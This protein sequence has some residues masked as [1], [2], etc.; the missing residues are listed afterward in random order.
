MSKNTTVL[1]VKAKAENA[2]LIKMP[3]FLHEAAY[4]CKD[5]YKYIDSSDEGVLVKIPDKK[6]KKI[7]E[8]AAKMAERLIKLCNKTEGFSNGP[9]LR[10]I[11]GKKYK[12]ALQIIHSSVN[13]E[14]APYWDKE[15]WSVAL[16]MP[17]N[18]QDIVYNKYG[19]SSDSSAIKFVGNCMMAIVHNKIAEMQK[20][21]RTAQA[22]SMYSD[23]YIEL[24]TDLYNKLLGFATGHYEV[25]DY[26][27][28]SRS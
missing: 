3:D 2:I 1:E 18:T 5:T 12:N 7:A 25:L 28:T 24:V 4:V 11:E 22:I 19:F 9:K 21:K 15:L 26:T 13:S 17:Q 27:A 10:N 14:K 16:C 20:D 6:E 23:Y 8:A